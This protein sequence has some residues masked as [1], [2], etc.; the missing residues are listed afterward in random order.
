MKSQFLFQDSLLP[1]NSVQLGRLVF[2]AKNP[3]Q[4]FLDPL[5]TTPG[6]EETTVRFQDDFEEVLSRDRNSKFRS[7]ITALLSISYESRDGSAI[8]LKATRATTYQLLNSGKWFK[9]ACALHK[10]RLWFEEGITTTR[11]V[12]L[13]VGFRTVTDTR[14]TEKSTNG[15]TTQGAVHASGASLIGA[16]SAHVANLLDSTASTVQDVN[17]SRVSSFSAP[18]EQIYAIQYRKVEFK[19]LSS[20]NIDKASLE[21]DNRWMV[22]WAGDEIRGNDDPRDDRE[23]SE[24][25]DEE[26]VGDED[27]EEE[28]PDMLEANLANEDDL[29]SDEI[30]LSEDWE[31]GGEKE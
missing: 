24:E 19:W 26:D 6:P 4:E 18:G 10:T 3:Q 29:E 9:N 1:F 2:N 30:C 21:R 13:V 27:E 16:G 5:G 15:G 25:D 12:Y 14:I 11:S 17:Y 8:N 31:V 28:E 20:R 22:C 23:D 7:R